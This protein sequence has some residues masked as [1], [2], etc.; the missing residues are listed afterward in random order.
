MVGDKAQVEKEGILCKAE[1][2]HGKEPWTI[3]MGHMSG[4]I[5]IQCTT[6]LGKH[7]IRSVAQFTDKVFKY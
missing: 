5:R 6:K 2:K 3:T 4:T 1:S 7:N